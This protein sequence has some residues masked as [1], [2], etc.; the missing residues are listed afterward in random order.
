[1]DVLLFLRDLVYVLIFPAILSCVVF[2]RLGKVIFNREGP[3]F[4]MIIPVAAQL[5]SESGSI[6][7]TEVARLGME[8]LIL[9]LECYFLMEN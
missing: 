3:I 8:R 7:K 2:Q 9:K 4:W 1:M 6:D 5:N